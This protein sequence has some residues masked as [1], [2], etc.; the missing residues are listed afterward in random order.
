MDE[1]RAGTTRRKAHKHAREYE[2]VP[3]DRVQLLEEANNLVGH[4]VTKQLLPV[5]LSSVPAAAEMTSPEQA[6]YHAA[7]DFLARQFY[8]GHS[9]PDR[10]ERRIETEEEE[11]VEF[12]DATQSDKED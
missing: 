2:I 4:M 11:E 9:D 7:L 10:H 5:L 3:S 1:T 8:A 12:D 6:A